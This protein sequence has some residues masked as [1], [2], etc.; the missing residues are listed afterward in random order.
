M[1]LIINR[2]MVVIRRAGH[3]F[4]SERFFIDIMA[5]TQNYRLF[6]RH[7]YLNHPPSRTWLQ[8]GYNEHTA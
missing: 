6:W 4:D 3:A 5:K 1:Q 2:L 7:D 8:A